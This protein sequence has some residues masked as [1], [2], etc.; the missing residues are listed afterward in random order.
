MHQATT[1]S[2]PDTASPCSTKVSGEPVFGGGSAISHVRLSQEVFSPVVPKGSADFL[3][4]YEKLEACRWVG[5]LHRDGH[6]VVSDE[7]IPTLAL[8]GASAPYPDDVTIADT[9]RAR[10]KSVRI[11]PAGARASDLGNPRVANV[12]VLGCLS[13]LLDFPS[14]A[15]YDAIEER[16]PARFLELNRRAFNVGRALM[17][18]ANAA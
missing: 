12:I 10:T 16:V 5:Y 11:V 6:A 8:A 18:H 4:A 13:Q 1:D 3:L 17:E 15:W 9:L 7:S 14:E 2:W